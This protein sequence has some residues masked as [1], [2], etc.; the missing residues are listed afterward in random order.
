MSTLFARSRHK[1][2]SAAEGKEL[3]ETFK[4][5]L[6]EHR[7]ILYGLAL[8]FECL[9]VLYEGQPDLVHAHEER[10]LSLIQM[11]GEML[12]KAEALLAKAGKNRE[13]QAEILDFEF[14]LDAE[15]EFVDLDVITKRATM[16]SHA[17]DR[18]FA[19]R[20]KAREFSHD[21]VFKLIDEAALATTTK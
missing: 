15:K 1:N 4:R 20:P 10:L 14:A 19:E 7:Q 2:V 6:D 21:E 13:A 12:Q 17:Y 9:R 18:V 5:K 11:G 3:L 8:Y 16:L